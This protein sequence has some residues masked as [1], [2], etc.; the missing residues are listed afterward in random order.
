MEP[1]EV[2]I[3]INSFLVILFNIL[4]ILMWFAVMNLSLNKR[5]S[6][7]L[8]YLIQAL[9]IILYRAGVDLIPFM[10]EFR[11][12]FFMVIFFALNMLCY[13]DS[14]RKILF[15]SEAIVAVV[16]TNEVIGAGL[17]FPQEAIQGVLT[18][19]DTLQL[20][21]LIHISVLGGLLLEYCECGRELLSC[22]C[23]R[24]HTL[25]LRERL[26]EKRRG[27]LGQLPLGCGFLSKMHRRAE[28]SA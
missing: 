7:K 27:L 25:G 6:P 14:K 11:L 10:S 17:Y 23:H 3:E 13:T 9:W 21:S 22:G 19:V 26:F 24:V 8:T 5:Y 1:S 12:I 18:S 16:I 2:R 15:A 4:Y 28:L 20:L